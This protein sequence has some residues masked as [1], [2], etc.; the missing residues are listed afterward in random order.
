MALNYT[1]LRIRTSLPMEEVADRLRAMNKEKPCFFRLLNDEGTCLPLIFDSLDSV[2]DV[3]MHASPEAPK[4]EIRLSNIS[5]TF[6]RALSRNLI[7]SISND[8]TGISSIAEEQTLTIS[9]TTEDNKAIAAARSNPIRTF[10]GFRFSLQVVDACSQPR[11]ISSGSASNVTSF[12]SEVALLKRRVRDV[13]PAKPAE[14]KLRPS[15][16]N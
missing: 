8:A 3:S 15:S 2:N 9:F 14:K 10:N 6:P 12:L 13:A 1:H 16:K 7:S 11:T 5:A 4:K